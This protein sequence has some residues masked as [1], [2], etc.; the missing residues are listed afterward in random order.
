[1]I[2]DWFLPRRLNEW[3][4]LIASLAILAGLILS[5]VS[6]L[7]L[8]AEECAATHN[9]KF[10]GFPF[11][12]FGLIFFTP[13]LI[14]HGLAL[15]NEDVSFLVALML[16]GALG[17]ET[18]LLLVQKFQ[19]GAW[20]PICL[21]ITACVL[22]ASLCYFISYAVKLKSLIKHHLKGEYMKSI[23]KGVASLS[24]FTLGFLLSVI[25]VAKF[26]AIQAQ[27]NTIKKKVFILAIKQA[28]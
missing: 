19:I 2:I 23:W 24:V 4:Y 9:W 26:D 25:G 21:S 17:A 3:L 15:K 28:Q 13:L 10:F 8:C 14:L 11:E 18:K 6:H 12:Y 1:M 5:I 7:R 20:C 22:I 27:E 16:A